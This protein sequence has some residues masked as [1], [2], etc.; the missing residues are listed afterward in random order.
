MGEHVRKDHA[1]QENFHFI[2]ITDMLMI[3]TAL[4]NIM[5]K[6]GIRTF[7]GRVYVCLE[8]S[9]H[10]VRVF[11]SVKLSIKLII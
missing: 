7:N 3:I 8:V 10:L 11:A 4:G 6:I 9:L 5:L 1:L 2:I